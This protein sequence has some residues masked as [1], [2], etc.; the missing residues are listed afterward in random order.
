[1]PEE[2]NFTQSDTALTALS[3]A[4][5]GSLVEKM[6]ATFWDGIPEDQREALVRNQG[7]RFSP[8]QNPL[9]SFSTLVPLLLSGF[10]G[11]AFGVV[12]QDPTADVGVN[13]PLK[14]SLGGPRKGFVIGREFAASFIEGRDR[15]MT[16]NQVVAMSVVD[17]A[18]PTPLE[19]THPIHT[20][21]SQQA[22]KQAQLVQG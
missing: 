13:I 20:L 22:Q 6:T 14:A 11:A 8:E 16:F 15:F 4:H 19:H 3:P 1:M 10:I 12:Q 5:F 21:L 17:G 2:P 18:P 7:G 9:E